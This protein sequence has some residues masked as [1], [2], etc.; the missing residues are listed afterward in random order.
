V[1]VASMVA[2]ALRAAGEIRRQTGVAARTAAR[3]VGWWQGSFPATEVF[4]RL[5]A[6]LIGIDVARV[7][8][9]IV[10]RLGGTW[11][12]RL[13]RMLVWLAP[14]TTGTVPD[15]ARFLRGIA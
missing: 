13:R 1:I 12:K 10:E 7:P 11:P 2:V 6:Q 3:W 4:V 5:C 8:T 14:L 9:S 15:G